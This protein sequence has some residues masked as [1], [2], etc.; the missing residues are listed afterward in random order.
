VAATESDRRP[1]GGGWM[2][3]RQEGRGAEA[4]RRSMLKET[5]K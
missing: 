4:G 3:K 5:R 2:L 1:E